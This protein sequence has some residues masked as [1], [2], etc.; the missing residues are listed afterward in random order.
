MEFG[1]SRPYGPAERLDHAGN[2][3]WGESVVLHHEA[4]TQVCPHG[5]LVQTGVRLLKLRIGADRTRRQG[6]HK[7]VAQVDGRVAAVRQGAQLALAFHP[8]LDDDTRVHELS[9]P[10]V[11]CSRIQAGSLACHPK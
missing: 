11:A 3:L 5:V 10:V 1:H 6:A 2:R 4:G 9:L 8:E 7:L